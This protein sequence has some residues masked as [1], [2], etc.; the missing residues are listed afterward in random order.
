[1][2]MEWRVK[3]GRDRVYNTTCDASHTTIEDPVHS[4]VVNVYIVIYRRTGPVLGLG[5][6]TGALR[7]ARLLLLASVIDM[8]FFS[9]CSGVRISTLHPSPWNM[10]VILPSALANNGS[11]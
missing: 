1:M 3:S 4:R 6:T 7:I 10:V 9:L 2:V 11:R 8:P 5:N